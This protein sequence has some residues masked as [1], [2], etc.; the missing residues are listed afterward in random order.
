MHSASNKPAPTNMEARKRAGRITQTLVAAYNGFI[1][2]LI[3]TS[4][5]TRRTKAR[6][7]PLR[8]FQLSGRHWWS[9]ISVRS[10]RSF[11][12]DGSDSPKG[13]TASP[14]PHLR[15]TL[16][17]PPDRKPLR[18]WRQLQASECTS[19][20]R[21]LTKTYPSRRRDSSRPDLFR[22]TI[23]AFRPLPSPICSTRMRMYLT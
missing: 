11:R 16:K 17:S 19:G 13:A 6:P 3:A 1:G 8:L 12:E 22:Q 18:A 4:G 7:E 20:L 9:D 23:L 10:P 5:A 14:P 2:I 21:A 15:Y